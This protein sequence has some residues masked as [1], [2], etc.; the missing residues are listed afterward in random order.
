MS[1]QQRHNSLLAAVITLTPHQNISCM[2]RGVDDVQEH[3]GTRL[4]RYLPT[5]M[6]WSD[7]AL[8]DERN[9]SA[10]TDTDMLFNDCH[11][12]Q[13]SHHS[14][15]TDTRLLLPLSALSPC[16]LLLSGHAVHQSAVGLA[17]TPTIPSQQ[18]LQAQAC[19]HQMPPSNRRCASFWFCWEPC[20][21]S[22]KEAQHS[23]WPSCSEGWCQSPTSVDALPPLHIS[24]KPVTL[25]MME[26][27]FYRS[28]DASHTVHARVHIQIKY[29]HQPALC[30]AVKM[31]VQ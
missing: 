25:T 1:G 21:P 10:Q 27:H 19:H 9:Q 22:W 30:A 8:D 11:M 24:S 14:C 15:H 23:K 6:P 4:C 28:A 31:I 2:T 16:R 5:K 29:S 7:N 13:R 17:H 12:S 18:P 20:R 3:I 26:S